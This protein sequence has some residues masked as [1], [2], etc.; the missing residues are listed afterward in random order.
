MEYGTW[1]T[2]NCGTKKYFVC[3]YN[4]AS[5]PKRNI[6]TLPNKGGWCPVDTFQIGNECFGIFDSEVTFDNAQAFCR[7]QDGRDL[8]SFESEA[9][10]NSLVDRLSGSTDKLT[11]NEV[12]IGLTDRTN[13]NKF[14][15][16]NQSPVTFTNWGDNQ[17]LSAASTSRYSSRRFSIDGRYISSTAIK[18]WSRRIGKLHSARL[19]SLMRHMMTQNKVINFGQVSF[20][21]FE[22]I[23]QTDSA[24][25]LYNIIL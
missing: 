23:Y 17:P 5:P 14:E 10:V 11:H 24:N 20:F 1:K 25:K 7:Q 12:W 2:A 22:C 13:E 15:W 19:S 18:E 9:E 3:E 16:V 4:T 6:P 21:K 8:A